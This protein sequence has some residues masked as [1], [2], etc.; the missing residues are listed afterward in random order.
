MPRLPLLLFL[1]GLATSA[2]SQFPFSPSTNEVTVET[3]VESS[4]LVAGQPFEIAFHFTI[5]PDWHTYWLNHGGAGQEARVTWT[6]PEGFRAEP[7][8]LAVPKPITTSGIPGYGYAGQATHFVR[9]HA[10]SDLV[11]GESVTLSAEIDWQYCKEVCKRGKTTLSETF[12][13]VAPGTQA[14]PSPE[15]SR[16]QQARAAL[17]AEPD[18]ATGQAALAGELVR[19]VL[20]PPPAF[21]SQIDPTSWL[22]YG[23][24]LV[25]EFY[26]PGE[27]ASA[28]KIGES[29]FEILE[30]KLVIELTKGQS[31]K[32]FPSTLSGLVVSS[33]PI[34]D[35]D[36]KAFSIEAKVVPW[37]QLFPEEEPPT[38]QAEP[39]PLP[40]LLGVSLLGG[41]ILNFMPCVF[42][43][44]GLKIMGFVQQ[45]GQDRNK[46]VQ[47]GLVFTAGVVLSFWILGGVFLAGRGLWGG[48]FTDPRFTFAILLIF[49]FFAVNLIGVFEIG[50]TATSVGSGL[51]SQKGLSGSFWS[52]IFATLVATPCTAPFLGVALG[53]LLSVPPVWAFLAF[54]LMAL[55]LSL[56]YLLLSAKPSLIEKL[57][58]PGAWMETF[59]QFMGLLLFGVAAYF[60]WVIEAQVAEST[61]LTILLFLPVTALAGWIYG[62]W[63]TPR[64]PRPTQWKAKLVALLLLLGG[65]TYAWGK[66][67]T[68]DL[69][70]ETWSSERVEQALS[71][72]HPVY[73]DFTARWC[74]T[75]QTNKLAYA[76]PEVRHLLEAREVLLLKASFDQPNPEATRYLQSLGKNAIPMNLLFLPGEEEPLL[77][78]EVLTAGVVL[79]FLKQIP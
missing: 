78:P 10:P 38:S 64:R 47:H 35:L 49:F 50:L 61:F 30:G 68:R 63:G 23:A 55:G 31:G 43:V 40:L 36:R 17:A 79:D 15:G 41:F 37:A 56:P 76:D 44:I 19:V 72:G 18:W 77:L 66:L 8:R 42:P 48:Q 54:T 45:A 11:P 3:W 74:A 33:S 70:W 2:R 29:R 24:D 46:I 73:L 13:V 62:K 71:Q 16:M 22:Y 67:G 39:P 57:P 9:L 27:E 25:S 32:P 14:S 51:S 52:G 69:V 34:A 60:L 1:L 4:D 12:Q 58:R 20:E 6:L 75:C 26:S 28:V 21:L 5:A 7:L 65:G 53:S 59:K